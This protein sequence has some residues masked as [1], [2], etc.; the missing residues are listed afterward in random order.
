[1]IAL[2]KREMRPVIRTM[3]KRLGI[4]TPIQYLLGKLERADTI[5]VFFDENGEFLNPR[6]FCE[7]LQH[8]LKQGNVKKAAIIERAGIH[9]LYGYQFF[10]GKRIPCRDKV[11]QLAFAF[12]L[13]YDETQELL[14]LA[15]K[16]GLYPGDMRDAIII[17]AL[18]HH[19][20]LDSTQETLYDKSLPLLG[21][22][23]T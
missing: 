16:R 12:E 18:L 21:E 4:L 8:L 13:S 2:D 1:M 6:P 17:F 23:R 9:P 3:R 14:T 5:D 7:H 11:L 19:H 22:I 20:D 15:G 10:D